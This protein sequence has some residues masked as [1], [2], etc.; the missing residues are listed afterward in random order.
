MSLT[1]KQ[2][3]YIRNNRNS[4]SADKIA[5]ELK[6]DISAVLEFLRSIESEK[7]LSKS[8]KSDI[9]GNKKVVFVG[10]MLA[11]PILF[12]I[13]LE[14]SLRFANYRGT[15][16]LFIKPEVFEGTI[17]V[18]NPE[19]TGRYFFNVRTMP[20][21]STDTFL[22]KKPANGYRVFVMGGSTTNGYPYGYNATFS[23]VFRD[24]LQDTAPN[25]TIE[26]VN[27]ATSA[28]NTYTLYDQVDEILSY[29]PDLILIYSGHNEYYGAL[30]V[31]SSETFGA[32]PGF[33]RLYLRLQKYK[34]FLLVRDGV[35]H[36]TAWVAG[37]RGHE[38]TPTE[39]TLMQRM[40]GKQHILLEER[41]YE[42]GK[43]Q[44][45]SNLNAIARKFERGN[46]PVMVGSLTSNL[47]DQPPFISVPSENHPP[48]LEIFEQGIRSQDN[49]AF[50]VALEEFKYARDLDALRFRAPSSFN[51]IIQEVSHRYSNVHYVPIK[52]AFMKA[53]EHGLIGFNLMLEH[54]HPNYSGY[55]LM[56]ST[57]FDAFVEAG[58]PGIE[59]DLTK[60][61]TP[62]EYLRRMY[63]TEY[64][65]RVGDHRIKL[66]VN[67]WP[68]RDSP[69]PQGYPR[70]YR[71]TSLADSIAFS[72]VNTNVRWD[73]AKVRLAELY[74]SRGLLNEALLEYKGLMREQPY[75]D[76]PFLRSAR[77]FLDKGDLNNAKIYLEQALNIE[78]SAFAAKM[79]GAIEVDAGNVAR[80]I[81]LL[82]K[83]RVLEPYD[84][85]I[86]FNLS[87]AYGLMFKFDEADEIL[88]LLEQ[89][90]PN[91]PGARAWRIQLNSHLRR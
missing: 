15:L 29:E 58:N 89:T 51:K 84:P 11:I 66:L 71:P 32:F 76:S 4:K 40:V 23:R 53:S 67:G 20:S 78:L 35:T 24:M 61:S 70:N 36:F 3:N 12:F 30:G 60:L 42:L 27:V 26:V 83:A 31:G 90:N 57:F 50:D 80:G 41:L 16:D 43:L 38:G 85:Q 10:I 13:I 82:E 64:D 7:H 37:I 8:P 28:I 56:G 25:K 91:F 72:M 54:L 68:F 63:M 5:R 87:G 22:A 88:K 65:K 74:E 52:E 77:I 62:D 14:T 73:L 2:K 9:S 49:E 1:T 39:G 34:T 45:Q 55:H 33:I 59:L 86:L 17:V 79:L 75:N 19:F 6:I 18:P 44:F 21:P 47:I 48:A 69:N 46:I 81:E